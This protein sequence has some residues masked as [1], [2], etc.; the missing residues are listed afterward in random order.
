MR[1][2]L[3]TNVYLSAFINPNGSPGCLVDLLHSDG[4]TACITV[5]LWN[6]LNRLIAYEK[7]RKHLLKR[8]GLGYVDALIEPLKD[9]LL[10]IYE[11]KPLKNWIPNDED[12]NWVIQCALTS[13]ADYLISGDRDLIDLGGCVEGI[14]ILTPAEFLQKFQN[15][16]NP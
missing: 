12:D 5:H 3:D 14:L 6:E 2:V 15:P 10:F 1:V 11:E 16:N 4:I 8:H 13:R 9:T 7:I